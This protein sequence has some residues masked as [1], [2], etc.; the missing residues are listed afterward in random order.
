MCSSSKVRR[1]SIGSA[2]RRMKSLPALTMS[3][4]LHLVVC[5]GAF[6][7]PDGAKPY[8]T[9]GTPD[10]SI[11][12]TSNSSSLTMLTTRTR[13]GRRNDHPMNSFLP[14]YLHITSR[15]ALQ[16]LLYYYTHKRSHS[17]GIFLV[18][19]SSLE[20]HQWIQL[21]DPCSQLSLKI[22]MPARALPVLHRIQGF[23]LEWLNFPSSILLS[24]PSKPKRRPRRH[25]STS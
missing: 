5:C 23:G 14:N 11:T 15:P 13:Y 22:Y 12:R 6:V 17:S 8:L 1:E 7:P 3:L 9:L 4:L 19:F 21:L 16:S 18:I 25:S 24:S 2:S 20:T 10:A